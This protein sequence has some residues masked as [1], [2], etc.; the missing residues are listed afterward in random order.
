MNDFQFK[1]PGIHRLLSF[2]ELER[3]PFRI[4]ILPITVVDTKTKKCYKSRYNTVIQKF[5]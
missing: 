2:S 3:M 4:R 5:R 1:V